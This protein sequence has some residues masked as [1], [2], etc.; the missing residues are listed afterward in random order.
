MPRSPNLITLGNKDVSDLPALEGDDEPPPPAD[1]S[2][3]AVPDPASMS[4]G[5]LRSALKRL[6]ST[7][8]WWDIGAVTR[9]RCCLALIWHAQYAAYRVAEKR[10]TSSSDWR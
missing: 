3:P 6:S 8:W 2:D 4:V 7:R 1:G 5:D 9:S 10:Q